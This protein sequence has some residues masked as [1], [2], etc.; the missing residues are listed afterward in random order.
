[1]REYSAS[2][3]MVLALLTRWSITLKVESR[4]SAAALLGGM[5][6]LLGPSRMF[7]YLHPGDIAITSTLPGSLESSTLMLEINSGLVSLDPVLES[8]PNLKSALRR[9]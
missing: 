3:L 4:S 6:K 1:M 5:V 8:V 7:V 2:T 9:I